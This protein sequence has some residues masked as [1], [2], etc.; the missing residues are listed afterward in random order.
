MALI[1]LEDRGFV[2]LPANLSEVSGWK[3]INSA[4]ATVLECRAQLALFGGQSGG[5]K[6]NVLVADSAQEY[7]NPNFR[8]ILLRKSYSEMTNI[9]DE[10]ERIYLPLGGRKSDGGKIWRFPSGALMRLGYMASDK[11]I[12]LYT[13]KP[14]SWLGIDEAQFQTEK[15][16]R[17]LFPWVATPPEY[18]LRDR[19]R[20]TANPSTPWLKALFLNNECPVC[21]PEK[22][23]KP[24]AI[25]AGSTWKEDGGPVMLTTCFIP[26]KLSEN[27]LYDERKRGM[28]LSQTADVRKK[29]L[30]GCWCA[31]EGAFFPFL[32]ESYILPYS[33]CGEQWWM[34]HFISM[35][36]GYSGSAAATGLYFL[37]ENSRIYKIMENTERKLK[38]EEYA[39]FIAGLMINRLGPGAQRC[40][41]ISGYA[42]P[43]MDA[44]TG[45]GKSNL[46]LINGVFEGYGL[47]LTKAAKDSVGNAQVLSGKLSRREFVVTDMGMN[48]ITPKTYES[49]SSRKCDPDRPGAILKVPGDELDDVLDET[50]YGLNQFL[51]GDKKPDQVATEEKIQK[52]IAAGV[53]QRSIA[54]TRFKLEKEAAKLAQP[55]TFGRPSLNRA[56]IHR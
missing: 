17:E 49:L 3:P 38:S 33:E 48:N 7:D 45:T 5:G 47:T 24:C 15:R 8:G 22:S 12:E 54:V 37:H 30:E 10:M 32:N 53:D 28:L 29:L 14:I 2:P 39:H 21:H 35:D 18:G 50:L 19:I 56:Q 13:G 34:T 55:I 11:D 41:I 36:Y 27:P 43:A 6:S 51:T 20:I 23:V 1:L 16:V 44:H 31:T 46:D 42:D 52:L 4:Q 26:A 25:Y 40:R 9:Q